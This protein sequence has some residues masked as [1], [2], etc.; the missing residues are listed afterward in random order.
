MTFACLFQYYFSN[1]FYLTMTIPCAGRKNK[2]I[3]IWCHECWRFKRIL[4]HK[5]GCSVMLKWA[6]NC[7]KLTSI[8]FPIIISISCFF[9]SKNII[10]KRSL[11]DIYM[12][13]KTTD[14]YYTP[15]FKRK[16]LWFLTFKVLFVLFNIVSNTKG[17]LLLFFFQYP[18]VFRFQFT[19]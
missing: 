2:H 7:L 17:C 19:L 5:N 15:T 4:Q 12:Y 16:F 13:D 1:L 10:M 3:Y 11:F 6:W 18:L 8:S 14:I 9:L